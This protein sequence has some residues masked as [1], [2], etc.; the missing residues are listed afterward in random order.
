MASRFSK[1]GA[2]AVRI[3]VPLTV[4]RA[5]RRMSRLVLRQPLTALRPTAEALWEVQ[6]TLPMLVTASMDHYCNGPRL[7]R[8]QNSGGRQIDVDAVARMHGEA[9]VLGDAVSIQHMLGDIDDRRGHLGA[10]EVGSVDCTPLAQATARALA[11]SAMGESESGQEPGSGQGEPLGSARRRWLFA[12]HDQAPDIVEACGGRIT[13]LLE[14]LRGAGDIAAQGV[15]DGNAGAV[16]GTG[17]D[18]NSGTTAD[19]ATLDAAIVSALDVD[20]D[21]NHDGALDAQWRAAML[22]PAAT[23]TAYMTGIDILRK[24]G[25]E[26]PATVELV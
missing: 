7:V 10:D 22:D 12:L 25:L 16:G 9:G 13:P 2:N 8:F 3:G 5:K 20:R 1:G 23:T 26:V 4:R 21:V 18:A 14:A 24:H 17:S 6:R 15:A 19:T 11:S